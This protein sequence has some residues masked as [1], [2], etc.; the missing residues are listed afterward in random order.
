MDGAQFEAIVVL[1]F[2]L[3]GVAL[4][5]AFAWAPEPSARGGTA[6]RPETFGGRLVGRL[7]WVGAW[8]VL[9]VL[10]IWCGALLAFLVLHA[11]LF[12]LGQAAASVGLFVTVV[13]LEVTPFAWA[14][15]MLRRARTRRR[16][17]R[18][19]AIPPD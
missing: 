7:E 2:I 1:P 6:P 19:E 14:M 8:F 3:L 18:D 12:T 17:D 4:V 15:V 16:R 5:A 10:T 13:L 9:T 11:L